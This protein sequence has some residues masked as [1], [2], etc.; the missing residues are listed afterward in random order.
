MISLTEFLVYT[1]IVIMVGQ[2]LYLFL[3]KDPD[4]NKTIE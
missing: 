3:G 1:I 4:E 2:I